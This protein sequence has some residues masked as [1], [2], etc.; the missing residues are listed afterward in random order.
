MDE[1]RHEKVAYEYLCHLEETKKWIEDCIGEPL[2]PTTEL[3]ECLRNGVYLA[4]L[5][6]RFQPHAVPLKKIY[7]IDQTRFREGG[8]TFRHTDNINH[9]M[10]VVSNLGLPSIFMPETTV[11]F[12]VSFKN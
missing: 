5:A 1:K 10:R 11:S 7:D 12:R 2:P 8:L 9:W 6:H 4:K 3:E